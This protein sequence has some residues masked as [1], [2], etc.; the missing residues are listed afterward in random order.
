MLFIHMLIEQSCTDRID[1]YQDNLQEM[2]L[3]GLISKL[4][5]VEQCASCD[6]CAGQID[7]LMK[8]ITE[9]EKV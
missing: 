7:Y 3:D 1:I 5:V 6:G 9:K 4:S 2:S 8:L